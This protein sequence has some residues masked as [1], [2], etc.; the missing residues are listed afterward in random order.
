MPRFGLKLILLLDRELVP[1]GVVSRQ[2]AHSPAQYAS[3]WEDT[4]AFLKKTYAKIPYSIE[5]IWNVYSVFLGV[6]K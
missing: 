3:R 6:L 5:R 2:R 4:T 1:C